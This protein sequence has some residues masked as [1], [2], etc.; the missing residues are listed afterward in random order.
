MGMDKMKDFVLNPNF[1][2][3]FDTTSGRK[4]YL[5]IAE[6]QAQCTLVL[7]ASHGMMAIYLCK[8]AALA[9]RRARRGFYFTVWCVTWW[10]A[11]T[12]A[13]ALRGVKKLS[14]SG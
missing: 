9:H 10:N 7:T 13:C 2:V 6:G 3:Q 11:L 12:S 1:S 14:P 5:D 4:L 8:T